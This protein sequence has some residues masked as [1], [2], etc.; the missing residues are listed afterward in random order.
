MKRLLV[1]A[2]AAACILFAAVSPAFALTVKTLGSTNPVAYD[3]KS[4]QSTRFYAAADQPNCYAVLK[5]KTASGYITIYKGAL[6]TATSYFSWRGLSADGHR[7]PSAVYDYTLTVNKGTAS[8][9]KSGKISV[10]KIWFTFSGRSVALATVKHRGYMKAGNANVY[11]SANS[12]TKPDS[13]AMR[14]AGP[15]GLNSEI[16][17]RYVYSWR[18]LSA[19][20]YLRAGTAIRQ[21]GIQ[22]FAV[23]CAN[24]VRYTVTV[25]Q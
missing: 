8:A 7:L 3:I 21:N 11:V 16:M 5:V 9:T 10:S 25:I 19:T 2:A 1:V 20:V 15:G 17:Y 12:P 24:D 6:G 4:L 23:R 18:P 14:I 13:M 22:E